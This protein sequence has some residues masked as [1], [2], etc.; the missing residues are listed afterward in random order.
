M[1]EFITGKMDA[2]FALQLEQMERELKTVRKRNLPSITIS[3]EFGC[4]GY[5]LAQLLASKL[6]DLENPW[7]IFGKDA[8]KELTNNQELAYTLWETIP[9]ETRSLFTQYIDASLSN[10]PTD[11][12]IFKRMAKSIKILTTKGHSIIVGSAGA[13]LAQD[14]PHVYHF[15]LVAS[16]EFRF[17]R[18]ISM[19]IPEKNAKTIMNERDEQRMRF[20]QDYTGKDIRDPHLY[21]I[22]FNNSKMNIDEISDQIVAYMLKK[23]QTI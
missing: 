7:A 17:K 18:S 5:D 15:R 14:N 12:M 6:K 8:I 20:V 3:R 21:S 11:L 1:K 13:V 22:V 10:K 2:V 16:E 19:G 4:E 9:K 23:E